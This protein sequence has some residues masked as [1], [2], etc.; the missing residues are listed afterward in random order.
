MA[1]KTSLRQDL[2][3]RLHQTLSPAQ[4]KFVRLLEMNQPEVEEEVRHEL[5]EN[6][7]LATAETDGDHNAA[8][9]FN[10]TAE[11]IQLA[12]YSDDDEIPHAGAVTGRHHE[13]YDWA[14][15]SATSSP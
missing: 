8:D 5:E 13:A 2:T 1:Q 14:E 11:Q 15:A 12:D 3:Q 10:E 6:R 7:A 4:L 9:D